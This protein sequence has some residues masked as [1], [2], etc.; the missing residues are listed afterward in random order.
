MYYH[1]TFVNFLR[2]SKASEKLYLSA[3][4]KYLEGDQEHAYILLLRY[5]DVV[6]A[7]RNSKEYKQNKVCLTDYVLYSEQAPYWSMNLVH[8]CLHVFG[9]GGPFPVYT[10]KWHG[11]HMS[12][13]MTIKYNTYY[14]V[15]TMSCLKM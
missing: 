14:T 8:V 11:P 15:I 3:Y 6:Q 10:M 9:T 1:N 7:I 13:L 2:L 12:P 5:L 4:D